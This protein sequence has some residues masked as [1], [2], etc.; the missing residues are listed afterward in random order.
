MKFIKEIPP[1]EEILKKYLYD[2]DRG[3]LL[4]KDKRFEGKAV[5]YKTTSG[6]LKVDLIIN[7]KKSGFL[8]HRIIYF[9]ETGN[10]PDMIDHIDRNPLNNHISNLREATHQQN[11]FNSS[12]IS[13]AASKYKGVYKKGKKWGASIARGEEKYRIGCFYSEEDAAIAYDIWAEK[14][15]GEYSFLNFPDAKEE[16][17]KRVAALIDAIPKRAEKTSKYNGVSKRK[18]GNWVAAYKAKNIGTFADEKDAAFAYDVQVVKN[19]GDLSN[20][21]FPNIKHQEKESRIKLLKILAKN[22][23]ASK[24]RGV[25]RSQKKWRITVDRKYAGV[26]ETEIEAAKAY[27]EKMIDLYGDKAILNEIEEQD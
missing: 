9:L 13:G 16:D 12:P 19:S 23:K 7:G 17:K 24:Y 10:Q 3:L 6:Y 25:S 5:G 4:S 11:I 2:K 8:I 15:F 20:L 22:K 21:N 27:N 14:L 1:K 26:Y 18:S